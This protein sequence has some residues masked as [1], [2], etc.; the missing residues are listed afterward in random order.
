MR[1]VDVAK[2][3]I[4]SSDVVWVMAIQVSPLVVFVHEHD[5]LFALTP[6]A[7]VSRDT[8]GHLRTGLQ[9]LN[10]P[11]QRLSDANIAPDPK[12]QDP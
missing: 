11:G 12:R 3:F 1:S 10:E 5:S 9:I 7:V 8:E 6:N 2:G 4:L